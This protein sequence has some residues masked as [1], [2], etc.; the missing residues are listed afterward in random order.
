MRIFRIIDRYVFMEALG[1]YLLGFSGFLGFL[2]V[3]KLVL[4][5]PNLLDP[6]MPWKAT[7]AVVLLETPYFMTL[8]F[9]VSVLFATLMSMGRLAKDNEL[10]ALFTNGISLYRL[11]LPFLVISLGSSVAS[12]ITNEY[13]LTRAAAAKQKIYDSNP[14]MNHNKEFENDPRFTRLDDGDFISCRQFNKTQGRL[15]NIVYDDFNNEGGKQMIVATSAQA[16][17]NTL[18]LGNGSYAPAMIYTQPS[19]GGLYDSYIVNPTYQL[20]LGVDLRKEL[21]PIKTPEELSQTEIAEQTKQ[22]HQRGESDAVLNTDFHLRFSGPFASLAFA[23]V[24]MPLSLSAPR[25]ERLL[26]LIYTF[27]LVM[28]YYVIYFTCKLMG[29]SEALAPWLAAWMMNIVFGV[30]SLFIFVFIRK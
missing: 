29:H 9:P 2:I 28:I 20:N 12:Y 13:L 6:N 27:I 21:T 24:A 25:D 3:N 4:E 5:A 14:T 22:L 7:V 30:I 11:F 26:G 10:V 8:S 23:L 18:L 16:N 19:N 17:G 1:L 15:T